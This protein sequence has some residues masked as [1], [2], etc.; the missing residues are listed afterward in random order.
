DDAHL[1]RIAQLVQRTNQFN[2]T[3]LRH[4]AAEL[5][6]FAGSGDYFPFYV[7]LQD[8]FGDNGL[9][10]LVIGKRDGKTLEIVTWLMSCPVILR[11]VEEFVLDCLMETARAAGLELVRGR[12]VPTAKNGIVAEHYA[13]LGFHSRGEGQWERRVADYQPSDTPIQRKGHT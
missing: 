10:S 11:R 2:L 6:E 12:Y 13:K 9:V 1:P 3:T 4:T 7:T 8:R 5:K